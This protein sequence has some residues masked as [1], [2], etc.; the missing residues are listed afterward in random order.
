MEPPQICLQ[1]DSVIEIACGHFQASILNFRG[2][3]VWWLLTRNRTLTSACFWEIEKIIAG[4]VFACAAIFHRGVL[5][6][7]SQSFLNIFC[8]VYNPTKSN[9]VTLMSSSHPCS[10]YVLS[11]LC[12]GLSADIALQQVSGQFSGVSKR[13][14][15]EKPSRWQ[16]WTCKVLKLSNNCVGIPM[17]SASS[18]R[19][20]SPLIWLLLWKLQ[21]CS[22]LLM[23]NVP[24]LDAILAARARELPHL[25]QHVWLGSWV[26]G[27]TDAGPTSI[28]EPPTFCCA[29]FC[30]WGWIWMKT[31]C[32][33]VEGSDWP[34]HFWVEPGLQ[35]ELI[36]CLCWLTVPSLVNWQPIFV[37][38]PANFR[39]FSAFFDYSSLAEFKLHSCSGGRR[40]MHMWGKNTFRRMLMLGEWFGTTMV[41][42]INSIPSNKLPTYTWRIFVYVPQNEHI[43][44]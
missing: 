17:Y 37:G 44:C 39:R 11:K 22:H 2:V 10:T 36:H 8:G 13:H 32:L 15:I 21:Q 26:P 4:P 5:F 16:L 24:V 12:L 42:G 25:P 43:Q 38:L 28:A 34:F 23:A 18:F 40:F 9:Q 29:D 3:S 33:R 27:D 6:N 35:F 14:E 31:G 41:P 7:D 30:M 1:H 20:S 19:V